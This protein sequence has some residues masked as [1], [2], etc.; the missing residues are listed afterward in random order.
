MWAPF[1]PLPPREPRCPSRKFI[2]GRNMTCPILPPMMGEAPPQ[3]QPHPGLG[4]LGSPGGEP[5]HLGSLLQGAHHPGLWARR[6]WESADASLPR[7]PWRQPR[8]PDS[9]PCPR[10][11]GPIVRGGG[12]GE[13]RGRGAAAP[14][15]RPSGKQDAG[16][17]ACQSWPRPRAPGAPHA[18]DSPGIR[19][20]S[21]PPP[22]GTS[23][24]LGEGGRYLGAGGGLG[25]SGG[26][27][28]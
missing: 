28:P 11:T 10:D 24:L 23:G 8:R 13:G 17:A 14:G 7:A 12:G 1:P 4:R 9:Q 3:P 15:T 20:L 19:A 27:Q 2:L 18:P 26:T 6:P 25:A 5:G 22:R 21:P 16:F